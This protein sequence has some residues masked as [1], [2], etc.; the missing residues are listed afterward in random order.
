MGTGKSTETE[1]GLLDA[2]GWGAGGLGEIDR[3]TG[4]PLGVMG[5]F[6][7]YMVAGVV[8]SVNILKTVE[9]VHL[10]W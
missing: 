6:W 5:M 10:K 2:K 3:G 8:N 9:F 1:S 7:V 4:S